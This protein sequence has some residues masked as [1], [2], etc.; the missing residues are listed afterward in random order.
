MRRDELDQLELRRNAAENSVHCFDYA[1][2]SCFLAAQLDT[3]NVFQLMS[4]RCRA[5]LCDGISEILQFVGSQLGG[6]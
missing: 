2:G 6:C 3:Y 1:I 4:G 5:D